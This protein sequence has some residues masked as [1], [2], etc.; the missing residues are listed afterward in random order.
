MKIVKPTVF[1]ILRFIGFIAVPLYLVYFVDQNFPGILP[2]TF[3]YFRNI[4]LMVGIP[5]VILYFL[6]EALENWKMRAASECLAITLVLF[7]TYFVLGGGR[8]N[9]SYEGINFAI[10]YFPLLV[11]MLFAIALRYPASVMKH[12]LRS[13][14]EQHK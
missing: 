5:L 6:S 3:E 1:A 7:W 9:V 13:H 12:Y 4:V 8:I 2:Y 10:D 14:S 11:L